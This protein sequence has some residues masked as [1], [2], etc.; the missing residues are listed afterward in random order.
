MAL[1]VL[2]SLAPA[3]A[4]TVDEIVARH[5]K[6]LGGA[7]RLRAIGS[8]RMKGLVTAGGG[9]TALVVREVRRP[10]RVRTEFTYQGVT[11]VYA[12]DGERGWK[13]SPFDG[14]FAPELMEGEE[15]RQTAD[16]AEIEGPLADW[17]AKGHRVSLS[18]KENLGGRE[19]YKLEVTLSSGR[20]LQHYLDAGSY[21]PVRTQS[22]RL[23]RGYTVTLETTFGDYREVG[24]VLFPHS[25]ETGAAGRPQRLKVTIEAIEVNPTLDDARFEMPAPAR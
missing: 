2:T 8:V 13:V 19:V 4:Q 16:Q 24:G 20:V 15:A 10:D 18:G 11:G 7:E 6:A 23:V 17:K 12:F 5:E 21:L 3:Q 25:I 9:G 14:S 22:T 1:A